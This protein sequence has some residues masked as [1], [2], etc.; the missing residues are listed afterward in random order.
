MFTFISG[1]RRQWRRAVPQWLRFINQ[2]HTS[3]WPVL[4]IWLLDGRKHGAV[5]N[6]FCF[7]FVKI[8]MLRL[9]MVTWSVTDLEGQFVIWGDCS[10]DPA[11]QNNR[12]ASESF[13][14]P[15]GVAVSHVTFV[16][17]KKPMILLVVSSCSWSCDPAWSVSS[18]WLQSVVF[19]LVTKKA[20]ESKRVV[21][22]LKVSLQLL[23]SSGSC[24]STNKGS[25]CGFD[26][27]WIHLRCC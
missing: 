1:S 11:E 17:L 15:G 14:R 16:S 9:Q 25:G 4:C 21:S 27:L 7:F 10:N 20:E 5:S 12:T 8:Q 6:V 3:I 19:C 18:V 24:L 23:T 2:N 26:S 13:T 22:S